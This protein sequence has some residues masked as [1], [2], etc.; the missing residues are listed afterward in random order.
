MSS[1]DDIVENYEK[2]VAFVKELGQLNTDEAELIEDMTYPDEP[3]G[4][5]T[6]VFGWGLQGGQAMIAIEARGMLKE[7]GELVDG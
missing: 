2:L 1:I 3:C 4:N 6:D 7:I 5:E